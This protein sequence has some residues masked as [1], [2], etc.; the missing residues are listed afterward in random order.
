MKFQVTV[1]GFLYGHS[2]R[3]KRL[4]NRPGNEA[5]RQVISGGKWWSKISQKGVDLVSFYGSF[6]IKSDGL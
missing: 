4:E 2:N 5:S 6:K 3:L 1:D